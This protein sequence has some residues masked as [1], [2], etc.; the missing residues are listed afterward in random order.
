MACTTGVS[1]FA[2]D[3]P[4]AANAETQTIATRPRMNA[5]SAIVCPASLSVMTIF[6]E[7]R[8]REMIERYLPSAWDRPAWRV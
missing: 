4:K 3:C 5:Y 8:A 7:S 1:R 6:S 2:T